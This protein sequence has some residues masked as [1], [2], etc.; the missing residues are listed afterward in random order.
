MSADHGPLRRHPIRSR[1]ALAWG[2]ALFLGSQLAVAAAGYRWPGLWDFEYGIKLALLRERLAEAPGR[3]LVLFLGSSRTLSGVD[4]TRLARSASPAGPRPVVFNFARTGAG[5]VYQLLVLERLLGAGIRPDHVFLEVIPALLC[6]GAEAE[7]LLDRGFAGWADLAALNRHWPTSCSR[8]ERACASLVPC[9][10]RRNQVLLRLAP[11]LLP[12]GRQF[13][14]AVWSRTDAVGFLPEGRTTVSEAAYAEGLKEAHR[15]YAWLL[16][17]FRIHEAADRALRDLLD[18][19]RD[20]RIGVTLY[21][22]PEGSAFRSWYAPAAEARLGEY[23][24]GL[25]GRYGLVVVDARDWAQDTDF[26]DGHHLLPTGAEAFSLRFG[27]AAYAR[28]LSS[29]VPH[30]GREVVTS[31]AP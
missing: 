24:R 9:A 20:R 11:R 10:A 22:M 13:G 17:G 3:P 14:W 7:D 23:L 29:G 21:L 4:P 2:L 6:Y 15:Q 25:S 16:G 1:R 27:R 30:G 19:C 26:W 12:P 18:T 5:P 28:S 31:R 8:A